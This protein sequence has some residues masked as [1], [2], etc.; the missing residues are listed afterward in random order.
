MPTAVPTLTE[1]ATLAHTRRCAVVCTGRTQVLLDDGA[2]PLP[3]LGVRFGPAVHA[4]AARLTPTPSGL[5]VAVDRSG[6]TV[7][8]DP[9]TDRAV[10]E[11]AAVTTLDPARR[12]LGLRTRPCRRPIWA[13]VNLV[14]LDRVLATT[15][16]APLGEPPRWHALC[17]RHPLH[18]TTAPSS[19]E[20]LAHRTSR[21]DPDWGSLRLAVVEGRVGW[22]PAVAPLAAWFDDGSFARHCFAS[23]PDLDTLLADLHELLRPADAERV[24]AGLARP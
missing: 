1:L 9:V 14:W 8:Y 22:P 12:T 15:L 21:H 24:E 20:V 13:L 16:D 23:L 17:R 4:V 2:R 10:P 18:R 19:P 7:V 11:V 5:V 3:F 6:D